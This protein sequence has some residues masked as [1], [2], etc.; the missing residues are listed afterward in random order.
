MGGGG[1]DDDDDGGGGQT[2]D[3]GRH[4]GQRHTTWL[5]GTPHRKKISPFGKIPHSDIADTF[6]ILVHSP[7]DENTNMMMKH[8]CV[9]YVL[10]NKSIVHVTRTGALSPS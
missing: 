9:F 4:P 3:P 1:D 7:G 2:L 6:H 5:T 8:G 10:I